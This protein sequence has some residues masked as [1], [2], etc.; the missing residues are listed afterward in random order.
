MVGAQ[1]SESRDFDVVVWGATG[2]TGRLV[3]EYMAETYGLGG[4]LK[5]AIA[6]RNQGKLEE[7][8]SE[9]AG[10]PAQVLPILI[11]DSDDPDSLAK[12][13]QQ[14]RVVITTVGPY[15]S[16]GTPLVEACVDHGTHYCDLTG[17]VPWMH[18]IIE[19]YQARA[20]ASGAR[21]VHTCGFDSIPSDLGVL[22]VQDVMH[23]RHG[24]YADHVKCR[25]AKMSGAASG[26]TVE[27]LMRTIEDARQN[28]SI[29]EILADPYSLNPPN[30]PRGP[31]GQDQ[32][33]AKYDPDFRS[34]TAPFVMAGINTRV[35]RRSHALTGYPYGQDF[36]YD[37]AM[38]TAD[39][40]MG[41][42]AASM[43]AG[44]SV[45]MMGAAYFE[46]TRALMRRMLP[47][48]GE[49][50]TRSQIENGFFRIRL[51]AEHPED[52]DKNI[53]ATVIGDRDPGYGA[54]SKMLSE[55]AVCLAK[56][57]LE[58]GGGVWTPAASMGQS[59]IGRLTANAGM[60]FEVDE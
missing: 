60:T 43:V 5:W 6:G 57:D 51:F 54:T 29:L 40:P 27:S 4:E 31:D 41:Y 12:M 2:F 1:M 47:S 14:T 20:E 30:M 11:A 9:R 59:L 44:G 39:G 58:C 24:V 22:F 23:E 33:M 13:V 37:E 49:G 46:P 10:D 15:A 42:T 55:S 56:D 38:L 34:W 8:R 53:C 18:H 35:V 32:L 28:R 21:I 45:M 16:Y 26:G 25:V 50:P 36:R 52:K 7:V 3:V 48:Q 17:E 19:T